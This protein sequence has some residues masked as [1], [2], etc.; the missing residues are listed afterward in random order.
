MSRSPEAPKHRS[1][2]APQNTQT[3]SQSIR[4]VEKISS[5]TEKPC[6]FSNHSDCYGDSLD[7]ASG[8]TTS[9]ACCSLCQQTRGCVVAVRIPPANTDNANTCL[10]KRACTQPATTGAELGVVRTTGN[11]RPQAVTEPYGMEQHQT[12]CH[13]GEATPKTAR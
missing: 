6:N 7:V 3:T 9:A 11:A 4:D 2:K 5:R 10:L 8:I 12:A 13:R 1:T